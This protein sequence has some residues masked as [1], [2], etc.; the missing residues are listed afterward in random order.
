MDYTCKSAGVRRA[1]TRFPA[2]KNRYGLASVFLYSLLFVCLHFVNAKILI[3]VTQ[4]L[5]ESRFHLPARFP[6]STEGKFFSAY[7]ALNG[8]FCSFGFQHVSSPPYRLLWTRRKIFRTEIM[9]AL[10]LFQALPPE[11]KHERHDD[12]EPVLNGEKNGIVE[13]VQAI[14]LMDSQRKSFSCSFFCVNF[15]RPR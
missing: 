13:G 8:H 9:S 10:Y 12:H 1:L 5:L 4:A 6:A 14:G 15:A 7:I 3:V 11:H 2:Q